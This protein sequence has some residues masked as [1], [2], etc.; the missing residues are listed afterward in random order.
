MP[1]PKDDFDFPEKD[2]EDAPAPKE[3]DEKPSEREPPPLRL[4][5]DDFQRPLSALKPLAEEGGDSGRTP[6]PGSGE[7]SRHSALRPGDAEENL[8]VL[9]DDKPEPPSRPAFAPEPARQ[10]FDAEAP[11][12]DS[13]PSAVD[14]DRT[15]DEAPIASLRAGRA[16][17]AEEEPEAA[18]EAEERPRGRAARSATPAEDLDEE[19]EFLYPKQTKASSAKF[20]AATDARSVPNRAAR[21]LLVGLF[22]VLIGGAATVGVRALLKPPEE[23]GGPPG[24][25]AGATHDPQRDVPPDPLRARL[26]RGLAWGLSLDAARPGEKSGGEKR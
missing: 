23:E 1:V 4:L 15:M 3:E 2:A 13:A 6:P 12:T 10:Q 11:I 26:H 20:P 5:D 14:P 22:A 19:P 25:V 16:P 24:P 9:L 7:S 8:Y 18:E 21:I 17:A